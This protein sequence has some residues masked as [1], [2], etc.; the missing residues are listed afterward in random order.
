MSLEQLLSKENTAVLSLHAIDGQC[1]ASSLSLQPVCLWKFSP[2]GTVCLVVGTLHGWHPVDNGSVSPQLVAW[3]V[4]LCQTK[5]S[6]ADVLPAH[7]VPSCSQSHHCA[8]MICNCLS[9]VILNTSESG[10]KQFQTHFEA[11]QT[12]EF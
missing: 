12:Q 3:C 9:I 4:L 7:C 8:D 5:L 2:T 11:A 6:S 1:L 10:T